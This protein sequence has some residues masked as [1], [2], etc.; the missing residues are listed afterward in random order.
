MG[1][2]IAAEPFFARCSSL[3]RVPS[4][5]DYRLLRARQ[6]SRGELIVSHARALRSYPFFSSAN[7]SQ[8]D[9]TVMQSAVGAPSH[10]VRDQ[11][12]QRRLCKRQYSR[13]A[14]STIVRAPLILAIESRPTAFD[15]HQIDQ[16][17]SD[18]KCK[19]YLC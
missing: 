17:T 13:L 11:L 5:T 19:L 7:H 18:Q 4:E 2:V 3:N 14:S 10:R 6:L 15:P 9:R 12:H 1:A 16:T 8:I